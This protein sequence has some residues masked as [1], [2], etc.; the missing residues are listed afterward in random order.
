MLRKIDYCLLPKT[1]TEATRAVVLQVQRAI[2][3]CSS[4]NQWDHSVRAGE[5]AMHAEIR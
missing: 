2:D 1:A 4:L 5:T 3:C